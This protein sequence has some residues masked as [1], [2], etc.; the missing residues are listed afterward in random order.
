MRRTVS[1]GDG[2]GMTRMIRF[3]ALS[4]KMPVGRP[5]ASLTIWPWEAACVSA[6]TL[7]RR[8][9]SEFA[10]PACP[11][12]RISQTGRSGAT[13]SRTLRRREGAARPEA[14]VP[15][16]AGDPGIARQGVDSLLD[17]PRDLVGPVDAPQVEPFLDRPQ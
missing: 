9:A 3:F 13:A 15:V 10:Q 11:S 14:L 6:V 4:T 7:A 12:T 5:E 8:I 17:P 2:L 16:A 1:A